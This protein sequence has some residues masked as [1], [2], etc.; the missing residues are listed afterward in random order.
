MIKKE[1]FH[2]SVN[3]EIQ[4]FYK[5]WKA[6]KIDEFLLTSLHLC[7]K[8]LCFDECWQ[9]LR[10]L[11]EQIGDAAKFKVAAQLIIFTEQLWRVKS[12][13]LS[14]FV[15]M[16]MD[17]P[18]IFYDLC[19]TLHSLCSN[20]SL[21]LKAHHL[22]T[23][24]SRLQRQLSDDIPA[25]INTY[26]A[27]HPA[28]T[29]E[30]FKAK[31]NILRA[32]K[33][34]WIAA[35]AKHRQLS[36]HNL[37]HASEVKIRAK[38]A[39]EKLNL[40][41]VNSAI[42]VFLLRVILLAIE[43][44]DFIQIEPGDYAT[45]ELASAAEVTTWLK[46]ILDLSPEIHGMIEL[47]VHDIIVL[48]T[49]MVFSPVSTL[50]LSELF[51]IFERYALQANMIV[52]SPESP[53]AQFMQRI[54]AM[55][56]ITGICDK[57]PAAIY[58]VV[59][60]QA[61]QTETN[62]LANLKK[63]Y[64]NQMLLLEVFFRHS[65]YFKVYYPQESARDNQQAFLISIVPHLCMRAELSLHQEPVDAAAF[66]NFI[67][68]CQNQHKSDNS[69]DFM[70]YFTETFNAENIASVVN[71]LFF[72]NIDNEVRFC[73]SQESSLMAALST[74]TT[75]GYL[76]E[77]A[78]E[79]AVETL[80][81]NAALAIQH[82]DIVKNSLFI[83][84]SIPKTD[85]YNLDGFRDFYDTLSEGEKQQLIAELMLNIVLQAGALYVK[86]HQSD[87]P[88]SPT[89]PLIISPIG[90]PSASPYQYNVGAGFWSQNSPHEFSDPTQ[91]NVIS[92]VREI[93][94]ESDVFT[95]DYSP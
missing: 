27:E 26:L 89:P 65:N 51:F 24:I 12:E 72:A 21:Y 79:P 18:Q 6:E 20:Q 71:K 62:S 84:A 1:S 49:T 73:N 94:A 76:D 87:V 45:V 60:R 78:K 7:L 39:A 38:H 82:P 17:N 4:R 48:G 33:L 44:H 25:L 64:P 63:Y 61:E 8:A 11:D 31:I 47:I 19:K 42:D 15:Q 68:E 53:N 92:G 88:Y 67:R 22:D 13:S 55:T 43:C 29:G 41:Q 54:H 90:K 40:F 69:A 86:K 23:V 77:Q 9:T 70:Q 35:Q 2:G 83:D 10:Y 36:H 32:E 46:E 30:Q 81:T 14:F 3:V 74:L 50:D 5:K 52:S 85:A 59:R 34:P 93:V 58:E 16:E 37:N 91:R 56:L 95:E 66:V 75:C 28:A 57:T 80:N